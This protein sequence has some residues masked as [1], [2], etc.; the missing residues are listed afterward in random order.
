MT[1]ASPELLAHREPVWRDRST[2]VLPAAVEG[3]TNTFEQ[4]FARKLSENEYEVCCIPFFLYDIALGDVIA[5]TAEQPTA[6]VTRRSGRV[7]FRIFFANEVS[8]ADQRGVLQSLVMLGAIVERSSR[9]LVAVDAADENVG[10]V[11]SG[12]LLTAERQ[13]LLQFENG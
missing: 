2:S 8:D 13:G 7:V 9:R 11:I 3:E 4:L 6:R 12:Y 10:R 1:D 5:W